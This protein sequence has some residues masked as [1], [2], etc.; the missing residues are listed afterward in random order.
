[1][2]YLWTLHQK[3]DLSWLANRDRVS[4]AMKKLEN[5]YRQH[6]GGDVKF[7]GGQVVD[8]S[9]P[10][11]PDMYV[12]TT[13]LL[14]C[15]KN[16]VNFDDNKDEISYSVDMLDGMEVGVCKIRINTGSYER[17]DAGVT[18]SAASLL[19]TPSEFLAQRSPDLQLDRRAKELYEAAE[20][21]DLKRVRALLDSG[22]PVNGPVEASLGS[23]EYP[24]TGALQHPEIA[25]LLLEA[26]ANVNATPPQNGMTALHLA[27]KKGHLEVVRLLVESGASVWQKDWGGRPHCTSLQ[28]PTPTG[29][30]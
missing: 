10:R 21:G 3:E 9:F 25:K 23:V 13:C 11:H 5:G 30:K 18:P 12:V 28:V 7:L 1:M 6:F 20:Q 14:V 15:K 24:L 22:A 17:T 19:L 16:G 4:T 8:G 2:L 27:A 29:A 26:G